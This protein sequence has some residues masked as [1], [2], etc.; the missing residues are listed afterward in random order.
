MK[1]KVPSVTSEPTA[2]TRKTAKLLDLCGLFYYCCG[3]LSGD[4]VLAVGQFQTK[5]LYFKSGQISQKC[6]RQQPEVRICR[7]PG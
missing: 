2:S 6:H 7:W 3:C 1:Q 4:V 5:K